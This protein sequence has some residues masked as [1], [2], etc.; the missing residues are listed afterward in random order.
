MT[1]ISLPY[2]RLFSEFFHSFFVTFFPRF[3]YSL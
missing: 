3:H 1:P 2:V